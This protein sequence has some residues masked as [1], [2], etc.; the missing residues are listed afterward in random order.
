MTLVRSVASR[1]R[2]VVITT[3][4]RVT[5]VS[6]AWWVVLT[7]VLIYVITVSRVLIDVHLGL[8]TSS[9]DIGLYDQGA[10]LLS[11]FEAP[12]V[13]LMGRNLLGDHASIVM[14]FVVPF[15]WF[16]PGSETLLVLQTIAIGAGALPLFAYARRALMS[17]SL[18]IMIAACWLLN[19]AVNGTAYE[20]F[21]PDGFIGL[22]LP[23]ALYAA[24]TEK[25]RLYL[26]AFALCLTVKEDVALVMV[27]LGLFVALRKHRKWGVVTAVASV[28]ASVIGM[29]VLMRSLIGVPTRNAWRI[30]FGGPTGFIKE[31]FTDPLNVCRYLTSEERPLYLWKMVAPFAGVF[32]LVPELALIS[33]LV[34]LANIVSTFWYQFHIEYH[35]SLIAVPGL[36]FGTVYALQRVVMKYRQTL[37]VVVFASTLATSYLWSPLPFAKTPFPHWP[38]SHPVAVAAREII[39][40]IPDDASIA[41]FH[42]LAPHLAH[43]KEVYQFPTPFRTVLY[44]VDL[45]L[46]NTRLPQAD[47]VKYVVLPINR[48]EQMTK[49]WEMERH[50]FSLLVANEYWEVFIRR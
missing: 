15:Y 20:N 4:A 47:T 36:I 3:G 7:M 37:V 29:F 23:L 46:E 8:G 44:G 21:H 6:P 40:V 34:I 22:F 19:P 27:P 13:T 49:D 14:F 38:A 33:T 41:V 43:R 31:V 42:S 18:A 50:R 9:Y 35:Y 1:A 45:S 17:D 12:F 16:L 11:R 2:E 10:W 28:V 30:P 5:Q 24:L 25:W 32:L 26:I 39:T 48:D